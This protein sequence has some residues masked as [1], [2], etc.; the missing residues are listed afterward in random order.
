LTS[1]FKT[2]FCLLIDSQFDSHGGGLNVLMR[3]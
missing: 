3:G 1:T 2:I